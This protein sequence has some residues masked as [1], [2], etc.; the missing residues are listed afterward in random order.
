MSPIVKS[1]VL[2]GFPVFVSI[3]GGWLMSTAAQRADIPGKPPLNS[4]YLGYGADEVDALWRA[5]DERDGLRN[6]KT[7]L[8]LDLAFPLLYCGALALSLAI[9][10]HGLG[11]P[12]SVAWIAA[13][14][15]LLMLA[16]WTENAVQLSMIGAYID[17]TVQQ[18][19]PWLARVSSAATI[20]K[21]WL[22]SALFCFL[23][24]LAARLSWTGR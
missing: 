23:L 21:L 18:V 2:F 22:V 17:H 15:V 24:I 13:P 6:E 19:Q 11:R 10:W 12:F 7:F 5:L 16:D 8:Q 20:A 1:V 9:A 14:V 3:C 4:R